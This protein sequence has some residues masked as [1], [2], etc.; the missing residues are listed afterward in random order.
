MNKA[1]EAGYQPSLT[2]SRKFGDKDYT[3]IVEDKRYYFY[4]RGGKE[5]GS[6]HV[7]FDP[8]LQW[9]R[10]PQNCAVRI[11]PYKINHTG[12]RN[13]ELEKK[14]GDSPAGNLKTNSKQRAIG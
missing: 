8:L 3:G 13:L 12:S 1:P 10:D 14:E 6:L 2:I 7:T 5:Y 9:F 11:H 4:T